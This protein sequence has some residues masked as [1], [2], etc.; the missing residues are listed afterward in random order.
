MTGASDDMV[1]VHTSRRSRL[2]SFSFSFSVFTSRYS[3]IVAS[4]ASHDLVSADWFRL[5]RDLD[6]SG[7]RSSPVSIG[8][9]ARKGRHAFDFYVHFV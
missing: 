8:C 3:Y 9:M 2:S 5:A 1:S 6:K 4:D 7:L